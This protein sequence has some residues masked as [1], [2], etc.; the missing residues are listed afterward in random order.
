[1]FAVTCQLVGLFWE[2]I[3]LLG[4]GGGVG[5]LLKKVNYQAI[6]F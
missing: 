4:D 5:A 1:M 3:E 6:S 2:L